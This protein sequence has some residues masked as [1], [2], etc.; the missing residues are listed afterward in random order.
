[1]KVK[2]WKLAIFLL[3]CLLLF[4]LIYLIPLVMVFGSSF[5]NWKAGG[6]FE[7]VGLDNYINAFLHD[8]RMLTALR[9]TGS[10]VFRQSVAHLGIGTVTAFMLATHCHG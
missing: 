3:P 2:K 5:F 1:M 7:F 4:A 6:V 8:A 9:N 10:W